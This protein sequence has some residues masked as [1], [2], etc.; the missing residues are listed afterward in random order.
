M[1]SA[2]K[3]LTPLL[4]VAAQ[5]IFENGICLGGGLDLIHFDGLAL[6]L[7]VVLEKA[8]EHDQAGGSLSPGV[9]SC[10]GWI[11]KTL[12]AFLFPAQ[13]LTGIAIG[14]KAM[15]ICELARERHKFLPLT[16]QTEDYL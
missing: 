7:L 4:A 6:K 13:V 14:M 1:R 3:S 12:P 10:P 8:A 16:D 2:F 15:G 5:R 11:I 9:T